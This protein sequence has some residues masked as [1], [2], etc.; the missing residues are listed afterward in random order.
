MALVFSTFMRPVDTGFGIQMLNF[1]IVTPSHLHP[2]GIGWVKASIK[3]DSIIYMWTEGTCDVHDRHVECMRIL[4]SWR[5]QF[6]N[7]IQIRSS[8]IAIDEEC[9]VGG[10]HMTFEV[11]LVHLNQIMVPLLCALN[12][13][14][15][16]E[17]KATH[18]FAATGYTEF[19]K[20]IMLTTNALN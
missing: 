16:H 7:N 2:G 11:C 9:E 12:N 10:I 15:H 8:D 3:G 1:K 13:I 5:F 14:W 19:L 6:T 17:L 4:A 18:W 20:T